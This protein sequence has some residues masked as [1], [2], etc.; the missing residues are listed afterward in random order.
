MSLPSTIRYAALAG[1]VLAAPTLN[2]QTW[3]I[4]A[5]IGD[6]SLDLSATLAELKADVDFDQSAAM[7]GVASAI[8]VDDSSSPLKLFAGRRFNEHFAFE[9]AYTDL[10]DGTT[11]VGL[12]AEQAIPEF[13]V[14]AGDAIVV[15]ETDSV[16]GLLIAGAGRIPF[17]ERLALHARVGVYAY[18]LDYDFSQTD[19]T[20]LFGNFVESD[21]EGDAVPFI[22][23]SLDVTWSS[24]LGVSLFYDS[25]DLG[26][27][28][29]LIGVA[30]TYGF[31]G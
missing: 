29:D 10:D 27:V 19:T 22:G 21:S 30:V 14:Q 26:D 20:G 15:S 12:I 11:S 25:Y 18:E 24:G 5:G 13:G 9:L 23:L 17:S 31:G 8:D 1:L 7:P 3:Y 6:A 28:A 16:R 4:G 2:A